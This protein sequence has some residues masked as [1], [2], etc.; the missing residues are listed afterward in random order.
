M[1]HFL[2]SFICHMLCNGQ[3]LALCQNSGASPC[4]HNGCPHGCR[5]SQIHQHLMPQPTGYCGGRK[6][7]EV[8]SCMSLYDVSLTSYEPNKIKSEHWWCPGIW[9]HRADE[10]L[11][12]S[13]WAGPDLEYQDLACA[14]SP[15]PAQSCAALSVQPSPAPAQWALPAQSSACSAAH[16]APHSYG[17]CCGR[18]PDT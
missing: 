16:R 8:V 14:A 4:I 15:G 6:Q 7:R 17:G 1:G 9:S 3:G 5:M 18:L 11:R 13:P 12:A 10:R 2:M